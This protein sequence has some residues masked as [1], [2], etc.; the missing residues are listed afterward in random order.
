VATGAQTDLIMNVS[1]DPRPVL[2]QLVQ[3]L[4]F[5]AKDLNGSA[6]RAEEL[7]KA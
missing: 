2:P 5:L 1:D 4:R 3:S 7:A 6:D